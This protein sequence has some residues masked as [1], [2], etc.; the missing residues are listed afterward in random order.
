MFIP[1]C[2]GYG[3]GDN[4]ETDCKGMGMLQGYKAMVYCNGI[5]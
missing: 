4:V 3:V 1:C 2:G 5:T